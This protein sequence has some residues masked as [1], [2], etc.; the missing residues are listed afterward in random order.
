M[1]ITVT[2]EQYRQIA[3]L[4]RRTHR[5]DPKTGKPV[6]AECG[7]EAW[8]AG[9]REIIGDAQVDAM[10][11]YLAPGGRSITFRIA[12]IVETG[13]DDAGAVH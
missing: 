8:L 5:F 3:E 10:L 9:L 13:K 7:R 4:Q 11:A 6:E 2:E 12:R 1:T